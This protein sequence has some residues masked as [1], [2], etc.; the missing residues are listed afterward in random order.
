VPAPP[1]LILFDVDGTLLMTSDPL[2]GQAVVETLEKLYAVALPADAIERVDHA[3]QTNKRIA[4]LVLHAAGLDDEAV[5][6]RLD[7]WC[8]RSAERYLE[9]LAGASTGD[10]QARPGSVDVLAALQEQGHRLALL[11]GNP[12]QAAR[13]RMER[14]GLARFFREGEGAFGCDGETRGAL[15]D[16]ARR[17]AG[18]WPAAR[19][20]EVGDTYRDVETA[21]AAGVRSVVF[22]S[23]R[24]SRER[25]AEADALVETMPELLAVLETL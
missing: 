9:L 10:W 3:G 22:A 7:A 13:A 15:I 18:H 12:E 19:T 2:M 23:G 17:R 4:R 5:D 16:L 11:T 21:H 25:L 1:L 6:A 24:V 20:V 14:L 8:V